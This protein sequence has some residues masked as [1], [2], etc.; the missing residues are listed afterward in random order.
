MSV[1][2]VAKFFEK[3]QKKVLTNANDFDKI[4][5]ADANKVN[6]QAVNKQL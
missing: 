1:L 3:S 6:K 5:F 2:Q 4:V